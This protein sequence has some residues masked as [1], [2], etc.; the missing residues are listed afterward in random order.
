MLRNPLILLHTQ[1]RS[2]EKAM[3]MSP[4][5]NR[6]PKGATPLCEEGKGQQ[7]AA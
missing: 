3:A 7:F 6:K 1:V 2:A 5:K 4:G